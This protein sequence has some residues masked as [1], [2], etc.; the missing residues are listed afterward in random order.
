MSNLV[1]LYS[2][3]DM[4]ISHGQGC[5]IY[6]V[7]GNGYLDM[8]SG[9]GVNVLGYGDEDVQTAIS[10]K[11]NRYIHLSNFFVDPQAEKVAQKLCSHFD[12]GGGVIFS[13]SGTE[14]NEAAIKLLRKNDPSK[15][16]V[17]AFEKSFH[18]RTMGSL[19]ITGKSV[20]TRDFK[21]L[22]PN[23]KILPFHDSE[24]VSGFLKKHGSEISGVILE[25]IQG[26]GGVVEVDPHIIDLLDKSR[27]KFKF[28]IVADEIQSG[29][30][31]TGKFFAFQHYNFQPDII[32]IAK[33]L[34]GGLPLGAVLISEEYKHIFKPG[35]HGSTFA[36]NPLALSA[37]MVVLSKINKALMEQVEQLGN[38]ARNFLQKNLPPSC[39]VRGKGLMIG[40]KTPVNSLSIKQKCFERKMLINTLGEDL[41]RL[42]P[43]LVIDKNT[44]GV[45][46]ELLCEVVR[47][48]MNQ[49]K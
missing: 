19:S 34:G 49:T 12:P 15:K 9:I 21:P 8:F 40:V 25:F 13:N 20:I 33:A 10:E 16:I 3:F 22:V 35:D 46:L 28:C 26:A 29:L 24:L 30:G 2:P 14:A 27:E 5:Y 47:T 43:P 4:E 48:L 17:V 1:K 7:E 37:A 6:D 39:V 44:L 18:G 38:Y 42:L 23:V 32:T 36:P 41:V 45:G 31:R 11:L